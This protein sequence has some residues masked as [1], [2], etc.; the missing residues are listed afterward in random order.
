MSC[1]RIPYQ[2]IKYLLICIWV[3][4]ISTKKAPCTQHLCLQPRPNRQNHGLC[5]LKTLTF[6]ADVF[7]NN[8]YLYNISADSLISTA[9]RVIFAFVLYVCSLCICMFKLRVCFNRIC[10]CL[11]LHVE[12]KT[13][14]SQVMIT[15]YILL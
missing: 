1:L 14:A 5:L 9:W 11:H 4:Q 12:K 8:F 10:I 6:N 7:K 2:H 15:C 3:I 13:S